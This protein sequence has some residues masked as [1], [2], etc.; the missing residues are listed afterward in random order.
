MALWGGAGGAAAPQPIDAS[1]QYYPTDVQR[2]VSEGTDEAFVEHKGLTRFLADPAGIAGQ[3]P[4]APPVPSDIPAV[5]WLLGLEWIISPSTF[6]D[7]SLAH[8][9]GHRAFLQE[10]LQKG[11][12]TNVA[13]YLIGMLKAMLTDCAGIN[14][15]TDD[16]IH[17]AA[18]LVGITQRFQLER[19]ELKLL[20]DA[21]Y[22]ALQAIA[23]CS[24]ST[25]G[26][27][28]AGNGMSATPGST[29]DGAFGCRFP[30]GS[31]GAVLEDVA[32]MISLSIINALRVP[33]EGTPALWSRSTGRANIDTN[34]L[35]KDPT[36]VK[37]LITLCRKPTSSQP[38]HP[39]ILD[40][41][42]QVGHGDL[43]SREEA[44]GYY[45]MVLIGV[46]ALL[47]HLATTTQADDDLRDAAHMALAMCCGS[48]VQLVPWTRVQ[49]KCTWKG[50][51]YSGGVIRAVRED[52]LYTVRFDEGDEEHV[53]K[54]HIQ[55]ESRQGLSGR[56]WRRAVEWFPTLYSHGMG[57]VVGREVVEWCLYS[58]LDCWLACVMCTLVDDLIPA[59]QEEYR[60]WEDTQRQ[61]DGPSS[62]Y[63]THDHQMLITSGQGGVATPELPVLV[64]TLRALAFTLRGEPFLDSPK[65]WQ[66]GVVDQ[67]LQY[68]SPNRSLGTPRPGAALFFRFCRKAHGV[69][70]PVAWVIESCPGRQGEMDTTT[71]A[72]L[73]AYLECCTA[74]CINEETTNEIFRM[75]VADGE[76][77]STFHISLRFIVS[78]PE[79]SVLRMYTMPAGISGRPPP[80]WSPQVESLLV[81]TL[82]LLT[83]LISCSPDVRTEMLQHSDMATG[84]YSVLYALLECPLATRRVV[85]AVFRCLAAWAVIPEQAVNI[86]Y[87]IHRGGVL[88][89]YP[90]QPAVQPWEMR[91]S[92]A[93]VTYD[94]HSQ[95]REEAG[96]DKDLAQERRDR[97]YPQTIGFLTLIHRILKSINWRALSR[98]PP[99][100]DC[101]HLGHLASFYVQWIIT[102]IVCRHDE[103]R[104]HTLQEKWVMMI[105]GLRIV[106]AALDIKDGPP[107]HPDGYAYKPVDVA[108]PE[109]TVWSLVHNSN[110]LSSVMAMIYERKDREHRTGAYLDLLLI[111]SLSTVLA[112]LQGARSP[113]AA[114]RNVRG[115]TSTRSSGKGLAQEI[116]DWDK[117]NFVMKLAGE[118]WHSITSNT[119]D[120]RL[121]TDLCLRVLLCLVQ[122][123]CR[124]SH[125]FIAPGRGRPE[126]ITRDA[127]GTLMDI[128]KSTH[129]EMMDAGGA[130]AKAAEDLDRFVSR[131][132]EAGRRV[133]DVFPYIKQYLIAPLEQAGKMKEVMDVK[134]CLHLFVDNKAE[135][136][137]ELMARILSTDEPDTENS[138]RA[139]V[140]RIL[141]ETI[142]S[143]SA[144]YNLAHILC[145]I[146]ER[147]VE[148][149]ARGVSV[150]DD[151]VLRPYGS[152]RG[153]CLSAIVDHLCDSDFT[154]VKSRPRTAMHFLTVLSRLCGDRY[155]GRAVLR[156]LR[157]VNFV[158]RG[159]TL[160]RSRLWELPVQPS[161]SLDS[162]DI[163]RE[164]GICASMLQIASFELF[165][166]KDRSTQNHIL[167]EL[168]STGGT[169]RPLLLEVIRTLD[170]DGLPVPLNLS[171][172]LSVPIPFNI[173]DG[174]PQYSLLHLF[175]VVEG[176][177]NAA[178]MMSQ[179]EQTNTI[180]NVYPKVVQYVNAWCQL[181][182]VTVAI[183]E[184]SPDS[185]VDRSAAGEVDGVLFQTL[186]NIVNQMAIDLSRARAA[187]HTATSEVEGY[188]SAQR[189]LVDARLSRTAVALIDTIHSRASTG[190]APG[191][192]SAEQLGHLL[193][194]LLQ[195]LCDGGD[196]SLRTNL[197]TVLIAFLRHFDSPFIDSHP[198]VDKSHI[199]E[200]DAGFEQVHLACKYELLRNPSSLLSRLLADV[201]DEDSTVKYAA[202]TTLAKAVEWDDCEQLTPEL[203]S[204]HIIRTSLS[205]YDSVLCEVLRVAGHG[206]ISGG[207][208]LCEF[209]A[210]T[211][212]LLAYTQVNGGS[213]SL[214]D[215]HGLLIELHSSKA[216]M[217]CAEDFQSTSDLV[218]ERC[219]QIA[220][221]LLRVMCAVMQNLAVDHAVLLQLQRFLQQ[222]MKLFEFITRHPYSLS[223]QHDVIDIPSLQLLECT[224]RLLALFAMSNSVPSMQSTPRLVQQLQLRT[225]LAHFC[226]NSSWMAKL[227]P[228]DTVA[229]EDRQRG[230]ADVDLAKE[231]AQG[232]VGNIV[233]NSL[234]CIRTAITDF[235]KELD[236]SL[237][238]TEAS[239][240]QF[241]SI[242]ALSIH[243][244]EA[245][246]GGTSATTNGDLTILVCVVR[247]TVATSLHFLKT[248]MGGH[249]C[250]AAPQPFLTSHRA[251]AESLLLLVYY[252]RWHPKLVPAAQHHVSPLLKDIREYVRAFSQHAKDDV[253]DEMLS[254]ITTISRSL[255]GLLGVAVPSIERC[256]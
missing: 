232:I 126:D 60:T 3:Q 137:Q 201:A 69:Q 16:C 173:V 67:I 154:F 146:P 59:E 102:N 80:N 244:P 74:L 246:S 135:K 70:G 169:H 68:S 48:M 160:L 103:Q 12:V 159:L 46:S 107:V 186:L 253:A 233:L 72:T 98:S 76:P 108:T 66:E 177:P 64:D 182:E 191:K 121:V 30:V 101:P 212:F 237:D 213:R 256:P 226:S 161:A 81:T 210:F 252:I 55:L 24:I 106:R 79:C 90:Q 119:A 45:A 130:F 166:N 134:E 25:A 42:N 248:A 208:H 1:Q 255:A 152:Q 127:E 241:P 205:H 199:E 17:A 113:A 58:A 149:R 217:K 91:P 19:D 18:A 184:T 140:C 150:S 203:H 32:Y 13:K 123:H 131:P 115:D 62:V 86:F 78:D 110:L 165:A 238:G 145:G 224:T 254:F 105:L 43:R 117:G 227:I 56:G 206:D 178:E 197:Y 61:L 100:P 53:P 4:G 77:R 204:S 229:P 189:T 221:P 239:G 63:H 218:Q 88:P 180:L 223:K 170:L 171:R 207:K 124:L 5:Q 249:R 82:D 234:T 219:S 243:D 51:S 188:I 93:L 111:E 26:A 54:A 65:W 172:S 21:L 200:G 31:P 133:S 174:V 250:T 85:G 245:V 9:P 75:M 138:K 175:E 39:S 132:L 35:A 96:M 235:I 155:I 6:P 40:V 120:P 142:S 109:C 33:Q 14:D 2:M 185:V 167:K 139:L 211:S 251:M 15:P 49:A 84:C 220:I 228:D 94:S 181:V 144:Y 50:G 129:K 37:E 125:H 22:S 83:T 231:E 23:N 247:D 29:T 52:G 168:I 157:S 20:L 216:L 71:L 36:L 57:T 236:T 73:G 187:P 47:T 198:M 116:A 225:V 41:I 156:Y 87:H 164:F 28:G 8:R 44:A 222:H 122:A 147:Y 97:S 118:E 179:A 192:R 34:D 195:C 202:W 95:M 128:A 176:D 240:L 158:D 143:G 215:N 11:L 92:T 163:V 183:I 148:A 230:M 104:Y 114:I 209:Q 112:F 162:D 27:W 136:V 89:L 153:L 242:F 194:P 193:R 190:T 38:S 10:L 151:G 99:P 196:G 214:V 7:D 141:T